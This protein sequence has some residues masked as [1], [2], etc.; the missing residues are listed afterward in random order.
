MKNETISIIVP[1]YNAEKTLDRCLKSLVEQTYSG[2]QILLI[3]DGS[4]DNSYQICEA[5]A[6]KDNRIQVVRQK[7][8]GVSAARNRGIDIATGK[9]ITFVDA[10]DYLFDKACEAML[11]SLIKESVDIVIGNK[12]FLI[13][14]K[15]F[16][17]KLYKK[18]LIIRENN[19]DLFELDM[20]TYRFDDLMNKVEYLSCGV[21]AKLFKKSL[22]DKYRLRFLENCHYGEDVLFN[23]HI[24]ESAKR[25]AY[26]NNNVY[27]FCVNQ[28]SSTRQYKKFWLESQKM[29]IKNIDEFINKYNKDERFSQASLMMKATRV[30]ALGVSY[31]FHPDNPD[32]FKEQYKQFIAFINDE[33][34]K[35]AINHVKYKLLN[36]N[37]KFIITFL[38]LKLSVIFALICKYKNYRSRN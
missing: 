14:N 37:Q 1:I 20:F 15:I 30:S 17:N 26:I 8:S 31:F 32:S 29:F 4:K 27:C 34:Y 18:D 38:R 7:N 21:T 2:L 28:Q 36:R 9:Y 16:N 35:H 12:V 3:D 22:I 23:L 33:S 25:V 5:W 10:D 6:K 13:N 11:S 19:K 24:L